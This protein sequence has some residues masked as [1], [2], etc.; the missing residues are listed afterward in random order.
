MIPGYSKLLI[1]EL[2]LPDTGAVEIQARFDLVMMTFGG[3]AERSRAQWIKL[4]ED[5]GF[6]NIVLHEHLDHDGIIEAEV[7]S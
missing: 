1:H 2:I 6:C 5:A 4:L 7:A 3:G